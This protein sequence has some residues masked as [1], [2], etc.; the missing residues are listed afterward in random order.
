MLHVQHK[1]LY[2]CADRFKKKKN[3]CQWSDMANWMQMLEFGLASGEEKMFHL[4][5]SPSGLY[6]VSLICCKKM[7]KTI[8][9]AP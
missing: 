6:I 5:R 2:N 3:D 9:D 8:K 4:S 1:E 7:E